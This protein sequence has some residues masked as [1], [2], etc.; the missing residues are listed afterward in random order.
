MIGRTFD[1][2]DDDDECAAALIMV[3]D[4]EIEC[5]CVQCVEDRAARSVVLMNKLLEIYAE[6]IEIFA[7]EDAP[8]AP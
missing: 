2:I 5:M 6:K 4:L 7:Y 8:D 3:N 1:E